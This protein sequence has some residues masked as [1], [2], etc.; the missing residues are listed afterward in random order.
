MPEAERDAF[1]NALTADVNSAWERVV[2]SANATY[3]REF[4]RSVSAAIEGLHWQLKDDLLKRSWYRLSVHEQAAMLEESFSIND[5]GIVSVQPRFLPL[6]IA[7]RLVVQVIKRLR[8]THELDFNNVGWSN[9]KS[10][11]EVRNRIVHPK[12]MADLDVSEKE[13]EEAMNSFNWMLALVKEL[14]EEANAYVASLR[15]AGFL[16]QVE[17]D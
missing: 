5:R 13:V 12:S 7:V 17:G 8:P 11:I 1:T 4:I 3:R 15:A 14:F 6:S 2:N 10:T 9:L 16:V